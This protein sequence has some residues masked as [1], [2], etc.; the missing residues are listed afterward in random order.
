MASHHNEQGATPRLALGIAEAASA[1][2]MSR[3]G[4]YRHVQSGAVR[5]VKLGGRRLVPV[6]ELE[7][8]LAAGGGG[9]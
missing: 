7:R 9:V 6:A 1:L 2:G 4:L 5:T 3:G 8:L